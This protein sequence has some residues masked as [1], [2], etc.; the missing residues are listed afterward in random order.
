MHSHV[1][2]YVYVCVCLCS[3]AEG[4]AIE[5]N[6]RRVGPVLC[7]GLIV[8]FFIP[9]SGRGDVDMGHSSARACSAAI[10]FGGGGREVVCLAGQ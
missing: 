10:V 8:T 7:C 6:G 1:C 3:R 5:P 4:G 2:M 9:N